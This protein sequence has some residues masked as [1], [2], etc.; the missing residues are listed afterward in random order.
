MGVVNAGGAVSQM[1][2][3]PAI[4][5]LI[6]WTEWRTAYVVL[7]GILLCIGLPIAIL[8]V[9]STPQDRRLLPDGVTAPPV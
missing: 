3:V 6:L 1:L 7:G 4:M 8:L 2:L 9:R 5:A